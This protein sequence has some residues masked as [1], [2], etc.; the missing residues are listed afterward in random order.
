MKKI[1][2]LCFGIIGF[3]VMSQNL[4]VTFKN[5][6]S[7]VEV[8]VGGK[9]FTSFLFPGQ[10]VI[11]KA[12]LFPL[13]SAQGT[14]ITRGYPLAPRAGERVDHPHHVGMWLNYEDVNGFDYWNNS[15]KLSSSLQNRK[16]GTIIHT[17]I[18]KQDATNGLLEVSADVVEVKS[19]D[20]D[21]HLGGRDIDR[22][23]ISYI[24]SEFK[25][26]SGIDVSK[27]PL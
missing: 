23:I 15:T 24:I 19:T 11:K 27:D 3:S 9:L 5:T 13:I 26:T 22:E 20:G 12:V 2:T 6:K 18:V 7:S 25:K 8:L 14:T 17:S 16:M 4:P 21:S 10:D 1:F